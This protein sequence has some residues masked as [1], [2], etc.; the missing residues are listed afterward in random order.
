MTRI[1]VSILALVIAGA[2]FFLYTQP[3]YDTV[4]AERAQAANYDEALQKANELQT[5]KQ[6]LLTRY[7]AFDPAQIDRLQKLLPDHV[8]NVRLVLDL[9]NLAGHY[10]FGLANVTIQNPNDDTTA[11]QKKI[12][13]VG[14]SSQAH[15]SLTLRF[16]V[17]GTYQNFTRFLE[18]LESSLRIVDIE[19]LS[20]S[21]DSTN[22]VK[23]AEP[24]YRF[25]IG[26]RTYWLK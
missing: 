19:Q 2:V 5:L 4:L 20:I 26:L 22:A 7:N 3:T 1:I 25:D 6:S 24:Q 23:G 11:T 14:G 18:D 9:D 15:D 17:R 8:D 10:G 13:V 16:T 21:P 12:G